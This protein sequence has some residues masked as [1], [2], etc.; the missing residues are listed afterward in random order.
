MLQYVSVVIGIISSF[1]LQR[2][3]KFSLSFAWPSIPDEKTKRH[4]DY[5]AFSAAGE[6]AATEMPAKKAVH[7]LG[8]REVVHENKAVRSLVQRGDSC[9]TGDLSSSVPDTQEMP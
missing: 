4:A 9:P 3:L 7:V 6:D 2:R 5:P 1:W 8:V